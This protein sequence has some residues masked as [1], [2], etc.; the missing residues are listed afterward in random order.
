MPSDGVDPSL[1]N[2]P[3][4]VYRLGRPMELT[5]LMA[6]PQE[7]QRMYLNRLRERGASEETAA[8]MLGISPAQMGQLLRCCRVALDRPDPEAWAD[9]LHRGKGE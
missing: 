6:M 7:L 8:E 2:G 4:R 9:F 1:L 5:E 3:C